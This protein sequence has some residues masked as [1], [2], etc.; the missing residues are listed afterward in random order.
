MSQDDEMFEEDVVASQVQKLLVTHFGVPKYDCKKCLG[1]F[2][3]LTA[4]NAHVKEIHR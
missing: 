3:T 4:L 1:A 2:Y